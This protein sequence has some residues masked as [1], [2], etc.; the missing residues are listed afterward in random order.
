ML[1]G[2]WWGSSA[3]LAL[4]TKRAQSYLFKNIG[5]ALG[6]VIIGI[7]NQ[8]SLIDTYHGLT[9]IKHDYS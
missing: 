6:I 8:I 7:G 1:L 4:E 3:A 5:Q 9:A 2:V